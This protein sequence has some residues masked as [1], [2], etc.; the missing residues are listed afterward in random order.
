MTKRLLAVAA[1]LL[2]ATSCSAKEGTEAVADG[3]SAA[4]ELQAGAK[5]DLLDRAKKRNPSKES[6][7]LDVWNE[8][9][10][11]AEE[12]AGAIKN[13]GKPRMVPKGA[14]PEIIINYEGLITFDGQPLRLG[15]PI[16]KWRAVLP[17]DA[18]CR[19]NDATRCYWD[20]LGLKVM[21][22]EKQDKSIIQVD[23]HLNFEKLESWMLPENSEYKTKPNESFKGYLEIDGYAID[24]D[25]KFWEMRAGVD[26]RRGLDCG[27][28]DCSH[29]RGGGGAG[30]QTYVSVRVDGRNEHDRLRT[31][32]VAGTLSRN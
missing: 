4:S 29:P 9:V 17:K 5:D 20:Q 10:R 24:K 21:T 26:P 12:K 7:V 14:K 16:D 15:E 3:P 32:T 19:I 25:T 2:L 11:G 30:G 27:T 18:V 23:I 13:V 31:V 1:Y 22:G 28:L 8:I 6:S